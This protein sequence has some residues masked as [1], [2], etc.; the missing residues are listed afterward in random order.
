MHHCVNTYYGSINNDQSAI[1]SFVHEGQRYTVEFGVLCGRYRIK[2]IQ[3][4]CNRGCPEEVREMVEKLIED[5]KAEK[6][7]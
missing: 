6:A 3:S 7:A 4:K 1:Y 2:Q 5:I